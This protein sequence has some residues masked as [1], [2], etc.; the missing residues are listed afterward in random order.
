MRCYAALVL[1]LANLGL[2]LSVR[3]HRRKNAQQ[4]TQNNKH[5]EWHHTQRV[6]RF[7]RIYPSARECPLSLFFYFS[8]HVSVAPPFSSFYVNVDF[9][10]APTIIEFDTAFVSFVRYLD[11]ESLD[12]VCDS[13]IKCQNFVN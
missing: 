3:R 12:R 8:E 2:L 7:E 5:E 11:S 13:I 10:I 6:P 9:C 4:N 1:F